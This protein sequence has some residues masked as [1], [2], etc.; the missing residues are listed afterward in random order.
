MI[1]KSAEWMAK[2]DDRILEFLRENGTARPSDIARY[3]YIYCSSSYIGQRLRK[4]EENKL[5]EVK[6]RPMYQ[7]SKKGRGYLIG[8]Y[9]A[10]SEKYLH[11]I[12]PQRGVRN[13]QWT[14]LQ[15]EEFADDAKQL[16]E[17]F[18]S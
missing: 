12:D 7:I 6:E 10:E 9:D 1:R 11:E 18:R 17:E 4:L 3:D 13:Y 5:V 2:Y 14:Q 15:M 8:A 16:F